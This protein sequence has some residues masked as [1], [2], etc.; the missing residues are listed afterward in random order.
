[1]IQTAG[2]TIARYQCNTKCE[3]FSAGGG[4]GGMRG[5]FKLSHNI[6]TMNITTII[7]IVR[8]NNLNTINILLILKFFINHIYT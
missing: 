3:Y 5:G 2:D 1:V 6:A 4:G 8:K 7:I